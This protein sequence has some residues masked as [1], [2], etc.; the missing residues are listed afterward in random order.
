MSGWRDNGTRNHCLPKTMPSALV[1]KCAVAPKPIV[2]Q[3]QYLALKGPHAIA[4]GEALGHATRHRMSPERAKSGSGSLGRPG[5][6]NLPV[7]HAALSGRESGGRRFPR[8][9]PWAISFGPF[10]AGS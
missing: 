7:R 1:F 6:A 2:A 9:K 8:A 3:Y 4:Q 5:C 10:R